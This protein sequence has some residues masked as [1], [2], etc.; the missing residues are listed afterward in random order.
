MVMTKRVVVTGLGMV[1]P[2]GL[3]VVQ[4]WQNATAGNSGIAKVT[5]LDMSKEPVQ[6][7][8][9]VKNFDPTR[10]MSEKESRRNKRFV[11]FAVAAAKMALKDCGLSWDVESPVSHGIGVS[12]GVG[13]GGLDFLEQ[14]IDA[15]YRK[16]SRFVSPFTIPGFIAN[17]AAGTVSIEVGAKGPNICTTTACTSGTHG[18]GEALML[19]QTGRADVMIAG[20]AEACLSQ[21]AFAGFSRMKALTQSFND[22]PTK[23][24]RPF[25]RHRSGFVMG[26]GAGI[27]VLEE[28]EFAK[29]RGATIYCELAGYG[30][31]SDAFHMTSPA[32]YGAGAA[33]AIE[34]ALATAGLTADQVDYINAHGTSTELND[35]LETQA[36]KTVFKDHG[37]K[38]KISSTK[39]MTGHLLGA[40]GGIEAV[41]SVLALKHG[42]VPPTI[43]LE[44]PDPL[45]DLDY[46]PLKAV[47]F[48]M[49]T[50]LSNSFGFGGTNGCLIFRR[51]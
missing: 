30:M 32:P 42:I 51:F 14:Q 26:E 31:S 44:D 49:K 48:P 18:I 45:C 15:L 5:C 24:S 34:Q 17:M 33:R 39:S 2:L 20:G 23:G 1:C 40:A 28:L 19:I 50:V 3:D 25:D 13:V 36:I 22:A 41:F 8:G 35:E 11:Q 47:E 43:N 27:L 46:T 7:C 12:I 9:E 29:K 16:G 6:I 38:V 21:T 37:R 4:S 10:W